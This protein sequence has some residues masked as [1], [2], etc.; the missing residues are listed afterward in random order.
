MTGLLV[1][2]SYFWTLSQLQPHYP[3]LS[4]LALFIVVIRYVVTLGEIDMSKFRGFTDIEAVLEKDKESGLPS[5]CLFNEENFAALERIGEEQIFGQEHVLNPLIAKIRA[6]AEVPG[7]ERPIVSAIFF[8]PPGTGK[9]T[10]AQAINQALFEKDQY[11]I[12]V[13]SSQYHDHDTSSLFGSSKG[14]HGSDSY[15]SITGFLKNT[16]KG[17]LLIDE[18]DR[19][20]GNSQKWIQSWMNCLNGFVEEVS[21][22]QRLKTNNIVILFASNYE[23]EKLGLIAER[24]H[25]VQE[26]MTPAELEAAIRKDVIAVLDGP[27]FPKA[28]LDR[29]DLIAVFTP[30][31]REAQVDIVMK[32]IFHLSEQHG[33]KIEHV[34]PD[35]LK[36][37]LRV[38]KAG[39]SSG[40]RDYARWVVA[41]VNPALVAA[42]R[43]QAKTIK[44]VLGGDGTVYATITEAQDTNRARGR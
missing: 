37:A 27:V 21:N 15:G 33:I 12:C 34:H 35:V 16:G 19:V 10:L 42:K 17:V 3:W 23:H 2:C 14:Y 32:E 4:W 5:D 25:A 38:G 26:K 11:F 24:Y 6:N 28:F 36:A 39:E 41:H 1:V 9:T 31:S 29:M 30:L 13:D 20:N 7:R 22:Q 44:L 8:G 40:A 18:P 43:Q